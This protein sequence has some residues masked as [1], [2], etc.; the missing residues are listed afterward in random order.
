MGDHR[1]AEYLETETT[2]PGKLPDELKAAEPSATPQ[3]NSGPVLKP[4][5]LAIEPAA[6]YAGVSRNTF[7]L[8]FIPH[9]ETVYI[10]RRR[11]VVVESLDRCLEDLRAGRRVIA[12]RRRASRSE[13]EHTVR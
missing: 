5:L 9:I 6:T 11:F 7:Y 8:E 13:P 4:F 12:P 3:G 1:L 2:M 10:G